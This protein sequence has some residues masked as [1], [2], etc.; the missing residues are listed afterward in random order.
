MCLVD[1]VHDIE[2]L[3]AFSA[4]AQKK[5]NG[6]RIRRSENVGE[7]G[8]TVAVPPLEIVDGDDHQSTRRQSAEQRPQTCKCLTP[9]LD[10]I[11]QCR[12]CACFAACSDATEN[13]EQA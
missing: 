11:E 8:G 7:E 13:R 12:L 9:H 10:H 3:S 1:A 4:I 2:L 5:Q 6:R